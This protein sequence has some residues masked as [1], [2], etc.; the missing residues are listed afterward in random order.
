MGLTKQQKKFC[1]EYVESG[2]A[3]DA[4]KAAGYKSKGSAA[5][6]NASRML[7]ND[8]VRQYIDELMLETKKREHCF[9]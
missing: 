3:T 6:T 9:C 4:Y 7:T 5:N 8:K 2:N 1:Q